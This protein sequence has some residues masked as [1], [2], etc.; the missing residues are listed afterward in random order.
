MNHKLTEYSKEELAAAAGH[1]FEGKYKAE[2][3]I[4]ALTIAG[5]TSAT[6]GQAEKLVKNFLK[7]EVE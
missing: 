5:V 7:R 6:V 3:I 4:A 1:L 2:C